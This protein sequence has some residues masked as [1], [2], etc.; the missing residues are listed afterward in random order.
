MNCN[1]RHYLERAKRNNTCFCEYPFEIAYSII[2]INEMKFLK[3]GNGSKK[4][5]NQ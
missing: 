5:K 1:T 2:K 3:I 4:M